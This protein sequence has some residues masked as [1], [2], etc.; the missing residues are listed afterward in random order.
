MKMG[1]L[2]QLNNTRT[3]TQIGRENEEPWT[4]VEL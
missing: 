3:R 2:N 4:H 1:E